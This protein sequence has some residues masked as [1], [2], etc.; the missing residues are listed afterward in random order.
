MHLG[1]RGLEGAVL[2]QAMQSH[3][4]QHRVLE[5]LQQA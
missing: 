4:R 1:E 3:G 2:G 5:Q